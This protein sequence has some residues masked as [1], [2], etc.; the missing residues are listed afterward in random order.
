MMYETRTTTFLP[1]FV[2]RDHPHRLQ[3]LQSKSTFLFSILDHRKSLFFVHFFQVWTFLN[4]R[5]ISRG[6]ENLP[7][8]KIQFLCMSTRHS[9]VTRE[10]RTKRCILVVGWLYKRHMVVRNVS[11]LVFMTTRISPSLANKTEMINTQFYSLLHSS[12]F[13]AN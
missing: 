2:S 3:S 5:S 8:C 4:L 11:K 6:I 9:E 1:S 7:Q 13:L 12:R 10:G